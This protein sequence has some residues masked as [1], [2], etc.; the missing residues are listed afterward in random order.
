M[1]MLPK[2][3]KEMVTAIKAMAREMDIAAGAVTTRLE[4]K[5]I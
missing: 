3:P 1:K 4:M 2:N 5:A